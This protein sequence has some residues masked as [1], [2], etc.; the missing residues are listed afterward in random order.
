MSHWTR[1]KTKIKDKQLLKDVALDLGLRVEEKTK[2]RGEYAGTVKCDF[3]V[4]DG[5]GGELAVVQ[6]GEDYLIQMDNYYNSICDVVGND[7]ALLTREYQT[8]LNKR[9][10]QMLGGVIAKQEVDAQGYVYL[11]VNV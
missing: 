9:E 2:M 11:E 6:D 1:G 7:A 5:R 4:S 3:I 10:A 8:E